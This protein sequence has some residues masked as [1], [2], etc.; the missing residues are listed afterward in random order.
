MPSRYLHLAANRIHP[1]ICA[2][3]FFPSQAFA[4]AKAAN[5]IHPTICANGFFPS[6]AFAIANHHFANLQCLYMGMKA[7]LLR[8][9]FC[10]FF[11]SRVT[12]CDAMSFLG[13]ESKPIVQAYLLWVFPKH[14]RISRSKMFQIF[15]L[16]LS[17]SQLCNFAMSFYGHESL[18]AKM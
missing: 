12:I 17:Q 14:V 7:S 8:P 10:R 16:A 6:Q 3:G 1:T 9:I 4:I 2:N 18:N 15:R 13:H 5:R 11:P